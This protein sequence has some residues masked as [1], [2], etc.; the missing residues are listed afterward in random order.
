MSSLFGDMLFGGYPFAGDAAG[1]ASAAVRLAQD[2][3]TI[4][5]E[6]YGVTKTG[7]KI[8]RVMG[9]AWRLARTYK[10]LPAGVTLLK[11]YLTVKRF[12][13]DTDAAALVQKSI[14]GTLASAGQITDAS[15]SDGQIALYFDFDA[16]DTASA[17]AGCAPVEPFVYWYDVQVHDD[18]GAIYTLERG[19]IYFL[20]GSTRATS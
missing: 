6:T 2:S 11:A 16:A 1:A 9:D 5:L 12:L 19:K 4:T 10:G 18:G 13:E 3:R 14:T 7:I 15:T 20:R 8:T 17:D